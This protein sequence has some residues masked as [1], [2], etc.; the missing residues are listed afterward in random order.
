MPSSPAA[1][2]IPLGVTVIEM[3]GVVTGWSAKKDLFGKTVQNEKKEQLGKIDDI[4]IS[5]NKSVSFAIIGVGGFLG[6]MDR[7]VAIPMTQLKVQ[8]GQ[9][10]L[11]GATK[12]NLTAMPPFVYAH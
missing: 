11:T 4:I 2:L 9:L 5:P 3:Q 12:A 1:G 6:I 10:V 8:S 7:L